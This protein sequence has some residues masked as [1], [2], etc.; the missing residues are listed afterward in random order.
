MRVLKKDLRHNTVRLC[1]EDVDD[2]WILYNILEPGDLLT[3]RTTREI[4]AE[5][6]RPSSQRVALTLTIEVSKVE[7]DASLNR[8]RI[9]GIIRECPEEYGIK[10]SHHT[11]AAAPGTSMTIKKE[12]WLAHQLERLESAMGKNMEPIVIVSLDGESAC[13]ALV[14]S[15]KI[16]VKGEVEAGLP[17]K[18]DL[19]ARSLA[20]RRYLQELAKSLMRIIENEPKV[21][22]IVI[23]GP[24]FL[25]ERLRDLLAR[26]FP[27]VASK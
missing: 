12:R 20:E 22:G 13:I 10:G 16:D 18:M 2:L 17:G 19:E 27:E 15:F 24:G 4:K 8:L 21:N 6:G 26:E 7:F 1:L 9:Q 5:Q 11:I 25:K 3:S 14:R 23:T